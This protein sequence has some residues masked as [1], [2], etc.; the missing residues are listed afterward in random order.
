M[1][2]SAKAMKRFCGLTRRS[3]S[4]L[5]D[6]EDPAVACAGPEVLVGP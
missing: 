2:T 3:S 4:W 6:A 5:V 1:R